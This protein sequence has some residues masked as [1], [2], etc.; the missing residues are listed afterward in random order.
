MARPYPPRPR[1]L[2]PARPLGCSYHRL[3][4]CV[5][6]ACVLPPRHP[7]ERRQHFVYHRGAYQSADCAAPAAP[8]AAPRVKAT[9]HPT[10]PT[11]HAQRVNVCAYLSDNQCDS[12]WV[13]VCVLGGCA[14]GRSGGGGGG[15]G[16]VGGRGRGCGR[17][18]ARHTGRTGTPT[19]AKVVLFF[20]EHLVNQQP[21]LF[22]HVCASRPM[23][24]T[25]Y[26]CQWRTHRH[27]RAQTARGLR[28]HGPWPAT[29]LPCRAGTAAAGPRRA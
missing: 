21:A 17:G 9:W 26:R 4:G 14:R 29:L 23:L 6:D 8:A 28:L 1:P 12:M 15:G 18:P 20:R 27:T 3:P 22:V 11:P 13:R 5:G 10:A 7:D 24:C 19:A 16:G 25:P 2:L